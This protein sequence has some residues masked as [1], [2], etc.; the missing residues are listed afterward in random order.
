MTAYPIDGIVKITSLSG[1]EVKYI[2]VVIMC[3][4]MDKE[5]GVTPAAFMACLIYNMFKL[6]GFKPNDLTAILSYFREDLSKLAD[7]YEA[8]S[9]GDKVN[10]ES[11]QIWDNSVA[12]WR[13]KAFN[14]KE[15]EPQEQVQTPVSFVGVVIPALYWLSASALQ[16]PSDQRSE[17]G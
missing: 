5:K 6:A 11:I 16:S 2:T 15:M 7:D 8:A 17:E 3:S 12:I 10:S 4:K 9:D 13:T 1:E 14:F